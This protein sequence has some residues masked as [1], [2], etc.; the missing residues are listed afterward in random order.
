[1]L[2]T[3]D[4]EKRISWSNTSNLQEVGYVCG[5]CGHRAAT[6]R[7]FAA[8]DDPGNNYHI[9]ICSFCTQPTFFNKKS[10]RRTPDVSFGSP[11]EHLPDAVESVYE[12]AR[13]CMSVSAYTAV[14]LLCRK[15]LMHVAV[16]KGAKERDTFKHYVEY[17][18]ANHW[19]PPES[20]DWVNTLKDKGGDATHQI[21]AT[22]REDAEELLVFVRMLLVFVYEFP[23]QMAAKATPPTS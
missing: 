6:N 7:G 1:M 8:N 5:Y 11:I 23:R 21:V 17:L 13:R 12:E 22:T 2:E 20:D 9:Y 15:L 16:E 4:K 18:A 14:A 10:G 19:T 3:L